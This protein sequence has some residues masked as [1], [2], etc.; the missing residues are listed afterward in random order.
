[1]FRIKP[2]TTTLTHWIH[3]AEQNSPPQRNILRCLY[4][5]PSH[6]QQ[7][8]TPSTQRQIQK[9][10]NFFQNVEMWI[11]CCL[12]ICL[13]ACKCTKVCANFGMVEWI[14]LCGHAQECVCA[15]LCAG[16]PTI[17]LINSSCGLAND[18]SSPACL[19]LC[20]ALIS[21]WQHHMRDEWTL[22]QNGITRLL[23]VIRSHI[24]KW[25]ETEEVIKREKRGRDSPHLSRFN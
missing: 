9:P 25:M 11:F 24:K 16:L 15:R 22:A 1:M 5:S 3:H 20:L 7:H 13:S 17:P 18:C 12:S 21:S 4:H 19:S 2:S 14:W 8:G 10:E 23:A 6:E